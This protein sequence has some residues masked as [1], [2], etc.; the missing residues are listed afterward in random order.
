MK[1]ILLALLLLASPLAAQEPAT[2]KRGTT[3]LGGDFGKMVLCLRSDAGGAL[4]ANGT[5]SP[6]SCDSNGALRTSVVGSVA[7]TGTFWQA[8]QPVSGTVTT[9]PPSNA[10]T[11]ITQ[12]GGT[13]I[14]TNSGNKSAGTQRFVLATDQPN[15]TTPFNVNC[16]S[17]CTA[18]GSFADSS[19][20]TFGTSAI[21]NTGFVV[22]DTATNTVAEN[23][24]GAGRMSTNRIPYFSLHTDAGT[25]VPFPAALGANGGL[26]IEGVASGTVVP[27]SGTITAN[28]GT[29]LNTSALALD[30]TL[31]ARF[32]TGA[33]PAD[34]ESNTS[35]QSRIGV[36]NFVYDGATWDRW[37]GGVTQSGTWNINNVSGTVSLPT[38]ASTLAEQQTQTTA[39]QLIDNLPVTQGSTTSGQSGVLT[40][41][42]VTTSAPTYTN[43]QTS[44][45]SLTTAGAIRVD[46]SG[47]TQPVS[48][49]VTTTP[50][51]NASTNI[52]QFGGT[53]VSTGTGASGAGIPRVTISNDS[54][55]AANQSV[56]VAQVGGTNTVSGGVAGSQGVGG[57]AASGASKAGNP[58][59]TGGVFNTTQ[60]TVT[61][62]QA[63]ENQS[64]AR[65]AE[66]VAPGVEGFLNQPQ[67]AVTTAPPSYTNGTNAQVSL[68][69]NGNTRVASG[70]PIANSIT[71]SVESTQRFRIKAWNSWPQAEQVNT[72]SY[73]GSVAGP[74]NFQ[75][76]VVI[77]GWRQSNP[78]VLV[79]ATKII[80]MDNDRGAAGFVSAGLLSLPF[81]G[82]EKSDST[83]SAT[84]NTK[85]ITSGSCTIANP[86]VCQTT[87]NHNFTT[88][89]L[90]NISGA[91][92]FT[93][94]VGSAGF[95]ALQYVTVT[96]VNHF[97]IPVNLSAC[98]SCTATL[99]T[100]RT[101]VVSTGGFFNADDVGKNI[102]LSVGGTLCNASD[103]LSD[104]CQGP[105]FPIQSATV[106]YQGTIIGFTDAT[107]VTVKP[108]MTVNPGGSATVRVD[109]EL[110]GDADG[111]PLGKFIISAVDMNYW[112]GTPK[113]GQSLFE[114]E[115]NSGSNIIHQGFSLWGKCYLEP[116]G[117]LS[118]P[119]GRCANGGGGQLET[120]GFTRAMPLTAT[121]VGAGAEFSYTVPPKAHWRVNWLRATFVAANT[122]FTRAPAI[123][124]DDGVNVIHAL[125][126][127]LPVTQN[128]SIGVNA[129]PTESA[130]AQLGIS[131]NITYFFE[132]PAGLELTAG[133]RI[134]SS[135]TNIQA[136]DQWTATLG[137]NEKIEE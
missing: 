39:L 17:G 77:Q 91:S 133:A 45:Y 121:A 24:A 48:G 47:V 101:L 64:T 82:T 118:W 80:T 108:S 112:Q 104:R 1:K 42:A 15:L 120:E 135:T 68:D 74:E 66:I 31:T 20:F 16:V 100:S 70:W 29:N 26:K 52:T 127:I 79:T 90:I 57:L 110:L 123:V 27:I 116:S 130:R 5:Y 54:S 69:A 32:P 8:T 14:D 124:I 33:N 106:T 19:A 114:A 44:P 2:F 63:V 128:Q 88:G 89:D 81:Q 65:G 62:G 87:A 131:G 6:L 103:V 46:G 67:G 95:P 55:L 76:K 92:G 60:P 58:V 51:S 96:D 98:S 137:V 13:S 99:N 84:M 72:Q 107:H 129:G 61:T 126:V 3:A 115:I 125:P 97:S 56:N 40:Q 41:G 75:A 23:S 11:N 93:P 71:W 113:S 21:G 102:T 43:G 37:T 119:F 49:T 50:P 109:P 136:T 73:V 4:N 117:H 105:K 94:A 85:T 28:A 22:D 111:Q 34:N 18:G 122:T 38:G 7:V 30:T 12:L 35:S 59:Q 25:A 36:Y 83:A 134:R 132:L 10:S 9:S 86:T 53:N 78:N